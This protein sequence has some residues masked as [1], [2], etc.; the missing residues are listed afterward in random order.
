MPQLLQN[1]AQS[2]PASSPARRRRRGPMYDAAVAGTEKFDF[3][4]PEERLYA[5]CAWPMGPGADE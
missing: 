4:A 2:V 5:T 1:R 3:R